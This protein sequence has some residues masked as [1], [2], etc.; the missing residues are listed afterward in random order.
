MKKIVIAIDGFSSN[1]KSTMAKSLAKQIG[2]IYIDSGAMYRAVTLYCIEHRLFDGDKLDEDRLHDDIKDIKIEF[3]LNKDTGTPDT[4]LNGENVEKQIRTMEVSSKVSI[5][6]AIPFVRHAMVAMQQEMGK[7]KGIV[8]DGRDIGTVVFPDAELKVFVTADAEIRA[9]RRFDELR[10]KGD[11]KTT[12][13]E[14]LENLK[15]R[16]HLDQTRAE[17]PLKKADDAIL[18]DNSYMTIDEQM[19]WLLDKFKQITTN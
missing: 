3:F 15:T 18:L 1:G 12:F 2:Y 17:S 6:S 10:S 5:V 19:Q 13:E 9:Q 8:M 4:Y 16:D 14:V 11:D 7:A